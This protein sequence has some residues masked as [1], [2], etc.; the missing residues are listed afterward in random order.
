MNGVL[1]LTW[2]DKSDWG[3]GGW[4][5]EPDRVEWDDR[6]TDLPCL[7]LRLKF[8]GAWN[9]YVAVP[10]GHPWHGLAYD[11]IPAKVHFGLTFAGT[12]TTGTES[13]D[14]RRSSIGFGARWPAP[15]ADAWWLGFDCGHHTDL[16]PAM[17]A[18]LA[19]VLQRVRVEDAPLDQTYRPLAFVRD[20]ITALAQQAREA[21]C[22][23][24]D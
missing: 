14:V 17:A 23:T 4:H 8:T 3:N 15:F 2:I 20:Q 13:E 16:C 22:P 12:G 10:R 18:R 11:A 7:A 5:E 1:M 9:G 19:M 24:T 6:T 21:T